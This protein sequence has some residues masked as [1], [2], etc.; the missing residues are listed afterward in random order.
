MTSA[1]PQLKASILAQRA[2]IDT[3]RAIVCVILVLHHMV[4]ISP[5][6]GLELP[7]DHPISLLSHTTEDMRMPIFS[8]ISGMV[9]VRVTGLWPDARLTIR[10]KARRLLLPMASVA[11]VFWCA[12]QL[13]NTDQIPL[14]MIYVSS[15][16]H[17]WFLQAS[18][19]IMTAAVLIT[20]VL[21]GA[22]HRKIAA[23]LAVIGVLWWG[24]GLLPLPQTNWFSITNAAFLLPFFMSG[25][26][27][28]QTPHLR[29]S[30]STAPWARPAGGLLLA[31]GLYVGWRLATH[32]LI[33]TGT[34]RR[35]LAIALG[36]S[37]C[38]GLLML[39]PHSARLA[40]VGTNAYAIYLFHVFF[41]AAVT[42]TW[43]ALASPGNIWAVTLLGVAI[44]MIGPVLLQHMI[45]RSPVAA[46]L[47]LGLPAARLRAGKQTDTQKG[48]AK[49]ARPLQKQTE[50]SA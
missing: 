25:Y 49:T 37:A 50:T 23:G 43:W 32:E 38:F 16:A 13:V 46:Q 31:I 36:A 5:S 15:F 3:L 40:R 29:L 26:L 4:G 27:V 2:E 21:G 1:Q 9:F 33:L 6:H 18:F 11:T 45:V 7:L 10:K 44:G 39:R 20:C 17:F 41:T 14:P 42:H 47:F 24:L 48:R 34:P 35:L 28:S 8:F 19:L 30:L 12:R 22:H